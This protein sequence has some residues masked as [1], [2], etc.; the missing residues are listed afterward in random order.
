MVALC[1]DMVITPGSELR[2]M[3][4]WKINIPGAQCPLSVPPRPILRPKVC[5]GLAAESAAV[6][7]VC[8]VCAGPVS[9]LSPVSPGPRPPLSRPTLAVC[10]A[11]SPGSHLA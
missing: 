11:P 3:G 8:D 6:T 4:K 2:C 7:L 9:R 1:T 10:V 5:S